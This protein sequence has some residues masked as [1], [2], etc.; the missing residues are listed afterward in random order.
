MSPTLYQTLTALDRFAGVKTS[1][2]DIDEDELGW[3][4][5]LDIL[6]AITG[7][8]LI[9]PLF[10]FIA[11]LMKLDSKGPIFYKQK[12]V[13]KRGRPFYMY[14]LRSMRQ[15]AEAKT[16]AVWAQENDPRVTRLGRFLRKTRLDEVPQFINVLRGEM[17]FVGPR[18]E[19]PEF[20]LKLRQHIPYYDQRHFVKPGITGWAQVT[21][22]YTSS[23][24]E[25]KEKV[26]NDLFYV[27]HFSILFDLYVVWKTFRVVIFGVGAR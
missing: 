23:I 24:E 26:K 12:R 6:F 10:P 19:R 27:K 17:S 5:G 14:K 15:D 20:V 16:G 7:L 25:T 22:S 9:L 13:G 8:L 2:N 11:L 4:R 1:N 18:P 21:G 3:K